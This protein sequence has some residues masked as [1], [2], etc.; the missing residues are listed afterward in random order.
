MNVRKAM[1]PCAWQGGEGK[2]RTPVLAHP[3]CGKVHQTHSAVHPFTQI[4][5]FPILLWCLPWEVA[6]GCQ[7]RHQRPR[8]QSL[9]GQGAGGQCVL[10][11]HA[12]SALKQTL[13]VAG[14][15]GAQVAALR[16]QD[17]HVE[18]LEQRLG[19]CQA[20]VT[21]LV[22]A[23]GNPSSGSPGVTGTCGLRSSQK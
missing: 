15:E 19:T 17:L 23:T 5:S 14:A 11:A 4:L 3:P 9:E 22:A 13:L 21:S 6:L 1:C 12:S 20:A 7:P 18:S 2:D 16:R 10:P 8:E